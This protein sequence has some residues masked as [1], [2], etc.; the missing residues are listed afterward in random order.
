MTWYDDTLLCHSSFRK[1]DMVKLCIGM[2]QK[3]LKGVLKL[4][5]TEVMVGFKNKSDMIA[6]I[7]HLT[8]TTIWWGKPIV[9]HNIPLKGRQVKES[10][11]LWEVVTHLVPRHIS[12][13]GELVCSLSLMCPAQ[14]MAYQRPHCPCPRWN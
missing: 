8:V 1:E 3:N 6:T 10:I 13:V 5:G 2:G 12:R 4:S 11:L 14:E 9:L 7:C